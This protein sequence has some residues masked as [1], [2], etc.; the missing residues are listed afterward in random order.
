MANKYYA[1]KNGR[2]TGIFESWAECEKQ[3]LGFS[4]AKYKSFVKKEDAEAYLSGVTDTAS[5][6]REGAAVAYVDGSYNIKT[7]EFSFGAVIFRDDK[8]INLSRAY[9]DPELATMRNVAG[10]IKGA[11]AA[12]LYCIENNIDKLDLYYD[13]QGIENWCTGEWKTT[14]QGTADYKKYYD[15]IKSKLD[16]KFIKVKGH[17]GDK[18]NDKADALAKN[19]LGLGEE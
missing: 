12:M 3:V 19:A 7:G 4:G 14:R 11:E 8:E 1:V 15:S 5:L 16:V 2:K 9:K 17:S 18:Y 6:F 13:Y 10:E